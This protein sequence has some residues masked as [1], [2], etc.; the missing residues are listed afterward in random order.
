VDLDFSERSKLKKRAIEQLGNVQVL[1][2]SIYQIIKE[3][4]NQFKYEKV[5]N[6]LKKKLKTF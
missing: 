4:K 2:E 1:K 5:K 6:F 3:K